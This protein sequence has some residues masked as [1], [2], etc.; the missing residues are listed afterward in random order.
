MK[1]PV[2]WKW[3]RI[4][5]SGAPDWS[6]CTRRMSMSRIRARAAVE[7]AWAE[8]CGCVCRMDSYRMNSRFQCNRMS[9]SPRTIRKCPLSSRAPAA[10]LRDRTWSPA[11]YRE[12]AVYSVKRSGS[13]PLHRIALKSLF[14]QVLIFIP[15]ISPLQKVFPELKP[16]SISKSAR[17]WVICIN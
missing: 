16:K 14:W 1:L 5:M 11:P 12:K 2:E 15:L 9:C 6:V 17:L 13:T 4:R 8:W 7:W 10:L 3:C